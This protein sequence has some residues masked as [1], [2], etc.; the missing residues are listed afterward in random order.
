MLSKRKI[1]KNS[2]RKIVIPFNITK[3]SYKYSHYS[4]EFT[5]TDY[6]FNEIERV[7]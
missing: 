5:I 2:K 6:N 1:P 3:K 7:L 4:S